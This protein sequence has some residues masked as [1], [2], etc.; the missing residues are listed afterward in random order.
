M[1]KE[2]FAVAKA[3]IDDKQYGEART[4]LK[5]I[6]H[7]TADKWLAKLDEIAPEEVVV[8]KGANPLRKMSKKYW[9]IA[10][11]VLLVIVIVFV[12]SRLL[13][14]T[15]PT[16]EDVYNMIY[17]RCSIVET[18]TEEDCHRHANIYAYNDYFFEMVTYCIKERSDYSWDFSN[19]MTD[20][21]YNYA[22]FVW[23]T[24]GGGN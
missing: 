2:K 1:L 24:M 23:R 6:D 13:A 16:R 18:S 17:D 5:T 9:A 8:E 4:I 11:A 10:G 3:F 12:V 20:V 21:D 14:P 22:G 19:C 7:P 15:G